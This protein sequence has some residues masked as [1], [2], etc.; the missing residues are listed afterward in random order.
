L[1]ARNSLEW[2]NFLYVVNPWFESNIGYLLGRGSAKTGAFDGVSGVV[3][4]GLSSNEASLVVS[5]VVCGVC[6]IGRNASKMGINKGWKFKR[7]GD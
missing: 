2:D 4:F 5:G 7:R 3:C 1:V 6:L